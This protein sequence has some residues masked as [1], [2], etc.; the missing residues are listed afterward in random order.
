MAQEY[1]CEK[2]V[3]FVRIDGNTLPRDRQS[4]VISF[5]TSFEVCICTAPFYYVAYLSFNPLRVVI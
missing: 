3:T 2:G 4:A 5:Q 1:L